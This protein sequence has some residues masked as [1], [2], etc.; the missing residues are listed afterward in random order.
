[1]LPRGSD[2]KID[3]RRVLRSDE[4]AMLGVLLFAV[5]A[6]FIVALVFFTVK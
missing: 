6:V 4:A 2:G 1:M 5:V 3:W